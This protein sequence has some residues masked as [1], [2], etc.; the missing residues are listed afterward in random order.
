MLRATISAEQGQRIF[1]LKNAGFAEEQVQFIQ[2][3]LDY[4]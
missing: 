1:A 3:R 4:E 2:A